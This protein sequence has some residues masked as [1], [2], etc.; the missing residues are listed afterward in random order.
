MELTSEVARIGY[1]AVLGG[2]LVFF[3][4][5]RR[6]FDFLPIAYLGVAFYFL[7]LISGHVLQSSPYLSTSIQPVVYL[8]ASAFLLALMAAAALTPGVPAAAAPPASAMSAPF[9]LLAVFGLV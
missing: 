7:P 4:L 5:R 9:L 8:I 3:A 2:G 1:I 6:Q